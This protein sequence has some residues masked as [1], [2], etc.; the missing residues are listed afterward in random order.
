MLNSVQT[1][2]RIFLSQGGREAHRVPVG[3]E[4]YPRD[5]SDGESNFLSESLSYKDM[6]NRNHRQSEEFHNKQKGGTKDPPF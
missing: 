6:C 2:N 1:E 3:M 4:K 5:K